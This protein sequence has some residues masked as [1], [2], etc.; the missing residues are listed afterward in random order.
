MI[1]ALAVLC[2]IAPALPA[3]AQSAF[4]CTDLAGRHAMPAVEGSNGVF[5]R[6]HPDLHMFHPFA[7]QTVA[8]IAR[9]SAALAEGGTTLIYVPLPTKALIE[10]ETLPPL[11]I[12]MGF[13]LAIATT[14]FDDIVDRLVAADVL[15]IN[16]RVPLRAVGE[17]GTAVIP[18][19]YRLNTAGGRRAAAA[20]GAVIAATPGFAGQPRGTFAS[21]ADGAQP[22]PSAMRDILQRHC[23]L[24]L[25]PALI[26]R[27][28]TTRTGGAAP[29]AGTLMGGVGTA[30]IALVG[31]EDIALTT[32]NLSGF[33]S[34]ST[35][36]DVLEYTVDG[37]E[38]FAAISAYVTSRA[39]QDQ[40]PA[41]LVWV[42]P[43]QNN[44]ARWGDQPLAELTAAARD[45]CRIPLPVAPG[46]EARTLTVDLLPLDPG[47]RYTLYLDADAAPATLARFDING[48]SGLTRTRHIARHPDQI[49]TGRFYL[50]LT[51][52]WP[53]GA[54]SATITLDA[55]FGVNARA[56]ACPE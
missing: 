29:L 4:G 47:R 39:F 5:Y 56:L 26:D 17:T 31:T 46:F 15:A 18:T 40:R 45:T 34:E 19:D 42:N 37:G 44:L 22:Q 7:D 50:P 48:P 10:P 54:Q 3:A 55:A 23:T 38:S 13:D 41:Y 53:E 11:A 35:G 1:R 20:I 6:V 9:L 36:L 30:Q 51:G 52:L 24:P 14:V 28:T 12:D 43:V 32:S 49:P 21:R 33:L 2:A 8:D 16:L 25:P 27:V